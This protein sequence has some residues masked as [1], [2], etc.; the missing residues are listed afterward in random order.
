MCGGRRWDGRDGR[1]S[2][3]SWA[4][5]RDGAGRAKG[6]ESKTT[7]VCVVFMWFYY[8]RL[9]RMILGVNFFSKEIAAVAA[10]WGSA[11]GV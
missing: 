9:P 2:L 11:C 6:R 8:L 1:G 4:P 10:E 7:G 5:G 3:L